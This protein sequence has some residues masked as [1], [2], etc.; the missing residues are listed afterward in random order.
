L[1]GIINAKNKEDVM[2]LKELSLEG[3]IR[4]ETICDDENKYTYILSRKESS[5]VASFRIPL[6]SIRVEMTDFEGNV[7]YFEL[8]DTFVSEE[9]AIRF[10]NKL[11]ENLATPINCPFVFEDEMS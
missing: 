2:T 5:M 10:F 3:I 1:H 6:Y 4:K 7:S 9:K 11:R 8:K